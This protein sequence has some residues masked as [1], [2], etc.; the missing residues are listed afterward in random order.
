LAED[1]VSI[2]LK[3]YKRSCECWSDW[4]TKELKEFS[5]TVE[6][7]RKYT[8]QQ[9]TT[10]GGPH[11]DTHKGPPKGAGFSRPDDVSKD[12]QFCEIGIGAKSRMH[13][14]IVGTVFFL[15]WLDRGHKVFPSK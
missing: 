4:Q 8:I 11:Y 14:F 10:H 1:T 15:V 12:I 7:L 5:K 13:G 9:L 6:K 2:S 3:Y